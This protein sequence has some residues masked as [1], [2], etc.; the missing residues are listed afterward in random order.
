MFRKSY[1]EHRYEHFL[2]DKYDFLTDLVTFVVLETHI[3]A[4]FGKTRFEYANS[5]NS[6]QHRT[7][8]N[9]NRKRTKL[10]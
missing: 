3:E 6:K 4:I 7:S 2:K 9:Q 8:E 10:H 1:F 5:S